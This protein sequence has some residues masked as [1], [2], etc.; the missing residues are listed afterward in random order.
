[1]IE[2]GHQSGLIKKHLN[3]VTLVG[4]LGKNPLDDDLLAKAMNVRRLRK[5][6]L[7]HAAHSEAFENSVF[8]LPQLLGR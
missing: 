2:S 4:K 7:S 1:M 8:T 5:K 3:E 6:D